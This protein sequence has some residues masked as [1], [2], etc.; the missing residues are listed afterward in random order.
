M[1]AVLVLLIALGA[2]VVAGGIGWVVYRRFFPQQRRPQSRT[3]SSPLREGV[4]ESQPAPAMQQPSSP[5]AAAAQR[6][7][8][9]A[10]PAIR[11]SSNPIPAVASRSTTRTVAPATGSF[12]RQPLAT[13]P[14]LA[15]QLASL[16]LAGQT[17]REITRLT[18]AP[19]PARPLR[20][21]L[22]RLTDNPSGTL[23]SDDAQLAQA[24]TAAEANRNR[25][26]LPELAPA[27]PRTGRLRLRSVDEEGALGASTPFAIFLLVAVLAVVGG[28]GWLGYNTFVARPAPREQFAVYVARFGSSTA[29]DRLTDELLK[30][31][32]PAALSRQQAASLHVYELGES[33]TDPQQAIAAANRRNADL[34]LWGMADE[35]GGSFSPHITINFDDS[36]NRYQRQGIASQLLNLDDLSL[37]SQPRSRQADVVALV[38]A[39]TYY[40]RDDAAS[41]ASELAK[42]TDK[43]LAAAAIH[44]YHANALAMLGNYR[45]AVAEYQQAGG[46]DDAA[47]LNNRGVALLDSGNPTAALADFNNAINRLGGTTNAPARGLYPLRNRALAKEQLGDRQGALED[48]N[49]AL[50]LNLNFAPALYDRARLGY[51]LEARKGDAKQASQDYLA[52]I[53]RDPEYADAYVGEG[54]LWLAR[55][56]DVGQ[57]QNYLGKGRGLLEGWLNELN[58]AQAVKKNK[59]EPTEQ[60]ADRILTLNRS[61]GNA[62]YWQGRLNI[63]QGQAAAGDNF[64]QG[65]LNRVQGK[66][67]GFE[68]AVADLTAA[69]ASRPR[70]YEPQYQLARAR[71]GQGQPAQALAELD[72]AKQI[73]PRRREAYVLAAAIYQQQGQ[74]DAAL[75][76]YSR[77]LQLNPED[78]SVYLALASYYKS[79]GRPA[80]AEATYRR[81]IVTNA[82]TADDF[83]NQG[84]AYDELKDTQGAATAYQQAA[85]LNAGS[86]DAHLHLAIAAERLNQYD[87]AI[88][89]YQRAA[90]LGSPADSANYRSGRVALLKGDREA[91]LAYWLAAVKVNP[92]YLPAQYSLA[93][94][95]R[96]AGDNGRAAQAYIATLNAVPAT[97]AGEGLDAS[98]IAADSHLQL[99]N[100]Y[101]IAGRTS[102]A[103]REYD[104][105]L[106]ARQDIETAI[107]VCKFYARQGNVGAVSGLLPGIEQ[108]Q[109]GSPASPYCLGLAQLNSGDDNQDANAVK[110]LETARERAPNDPDVQN[111]LGQAYLKVGDKD[112]AA[113]SFN[114]V[115]LADGRN[116]NAMLGLGDVEERKGNAPAALDRYK[117][118]VNLDG[119]NAAALTAYGKALAKDNRDE[120]ERYYRKAIEKDALL[121]RPH[122]ELGLV[123][124]SKNNE[125]G[126]LAQYQQAA[127]LRP[128]WGLAHYYVG[129][130]LLKKGD[131]NGS[132]GE[133]KLATQLSP[134]QPEPFA[135]LGDA[136]RAAGRSNYDAA[137]A[138][139]QQAVDLKPDYAEAWL[140]LG[141]TQQEKGDVVAASRSYAQAKAA[142]GSD[143]DLQRRAQEALDRLNR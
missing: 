119:N 46:L 126:A 122:L 134:R 77:L 25:P 124:T 131:M 10:S 61:L 24:V 26:Y 84:L 140:S 132:L 8:T 16:P 57:A 110:N 32:L 111:A 67:N 52:A 103:A 135:A 118:A 82:S 102:D 59:N 13:G 112:K 109:A 12:S 100:L 11:R 85:K 20:G 43:P 86:A 123:L 50:K 64:F 63:V 29:S 73:D 56:N 139:Y 81:A 74:T 129:R 113:Q 41:A 33:V 39:L 116:S 1:D 2:V 120:A 95:Y 28:V 18:P 125:A 68:Q 117:Q 88:G 106:T 14:A 94:Y 65:V 9:P 89:E 114:A 105:V 49:L 87:L 93:Q 5:L 76:Q 37:G 6:S 136:Y 30:R 7:S 75:A 51:D 58:T 91:A 55:L 54:A 40:G 138:A 71:W 143:P 53:S 62:Q 23:G 31:D 98:V 60:I 36:P 72:K 78:S 44:F 45:A 104:A 34:L 17:T 107:L 99:G 3:A 92:G 101:Q 79:L 42:L 130:S 47:T 108:L 83:Y 96:Q 35:G 66:V 127:S 22:R 133:L 80:D 4:V 137:S 97:A 15:A 128:T 90:Q 38:A 27:R 48:I 19:T 141:Q 121:A 21:R 142:A 115:L 69:L 70:W